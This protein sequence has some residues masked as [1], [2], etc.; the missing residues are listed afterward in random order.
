MFK[1][2]LFRRQV[3][4]FN[5]KSTGRVSRIIDVINPAVQT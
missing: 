2:F 4:G 1:G 3:V 5:A